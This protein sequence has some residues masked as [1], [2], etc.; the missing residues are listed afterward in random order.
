MSEVEFAL[1]VLNYEESFS[2]SINGTDTLSKGVL[3]SEEVFAWWKSSNCI[4]T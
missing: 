3:L 1:H 4:D 2:S